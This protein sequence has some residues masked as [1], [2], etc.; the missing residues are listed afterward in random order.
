VTLAVSPIT[1]EK[2]ASVPIDVPALLRCWH[3]LSLDAPTVAAVWAW[4]FAH[5]FQ[6][7]LPVV[8]IAILTLGTWIIYISDRLLDGWRTLR[9]SEMRERHHFHFRHRCSLLIAGGCISAVLL[10]LIVERMSV[11]ARR[12]DTILFLV[13]LVYFMTIHSRPSNLRFAFPKELAVG[14]IF[15]AATAIPAWSRLQR[16]PVALI[17]AIILFAILCWLNC[18]GIERW[19]NPEKFQHHNFR[20][21]LMAM[22]I[23]SIG[24]LLAAYYSNSRATQLYAAEAISAGLL[25]SLDSS[26][27]KFTP[28]ALRIGAD[29]ALLTPLLILPW[30][31]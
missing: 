24:G 29:L 19:E 4:I 17:G 7:Q 11:P 3:V 31:S 14:S 6:V 5:S 18:F 20:F 13:A 1:T 25:L 2:S 9:P 26:Q 30:S 27:L 8:S 16:H 10:W 28:M 23:C 21:V 15:A 12:E 22:I